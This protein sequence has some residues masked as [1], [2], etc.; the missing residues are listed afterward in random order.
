[1]TSAGVWFLLGVAIAVAGSRLQFG[2]WDTPGPGFVP[3]LAGVVLAALATAVF[4][5]EWRAART[6][7]RTPAALPDRR[8]VWRVA[9]T[10]V[11]LF[12]YALLLMPLGFVLTTLLVLGFLFRCIAGLG[13]IV[14]LASTVAATAGSYVLFSVWLK[15]P[16]PPGLWRP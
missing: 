7:P 15:V 13:W 4:V 5:T 12:G 1:M 10:V 2:S 9:G 14:S 11:A 6:R 8:L 3:T 16:F